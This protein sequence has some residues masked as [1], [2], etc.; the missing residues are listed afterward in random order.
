MQTSGVGGGVTSASFTSNPQ[1]LLKVL[2]PPPH[3]PTHPY[4]HTQTHPPPPIL[5][6]RA[7]QAAAAVAAAVELALAKPAVHVVLSQAKP[8]A[9]RG[10]VPATL[11]AIGVYALASGGRRI[12]GEVP[13]SLKIKKSTQFSCF[14]GTKAQI[15]TQKM[16]LL[17]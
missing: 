1:F 3:P 8:P 2:A 14:T 13:P 6:P 12:E 15:L 10:G 17:L 11:Q 5:A 9:L 16:L 7:S 4:T